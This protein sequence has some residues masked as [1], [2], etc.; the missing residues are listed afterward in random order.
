MRGKA[1]AYNASC[2]RGRITPAH[3]GKSLSPLYQFF[4]V[5][6]HP[7]ACGEKHYIIIQPGC[8]QG[9]PPRMRGK[10]VIRL[11]DK[12]YYGITPAHAGKRYHPSFSCLKFKDHPRACGEKFNDFIASSNRLGSPPRMRGKDIVEPITTTHSGITPAH[13]GK[14][15]VRFARGAER[16]DHPRA[17]GEK[18]KR[19]RSYAH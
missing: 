11:R 7:R 1:C 9:S 16:R 14:S 13:A 8:Q 19:S 18:T 10:G 15:G 5:K 4:C 2:Q 17:C 3:A 6:D 12:L